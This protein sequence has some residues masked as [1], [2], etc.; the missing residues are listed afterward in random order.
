[1]AG[2]DDFITTAARDMGEPEHT[3]RAATGALLGLIR[4]HA[5]SS[6][7]DQLL[8]AIPGASAIM[9]PPVQRSA[10]SGLLGGLL[11]SAASKLG[12]GSSVGGAISVLE[13]IHSTGFS[14]HNVT[15]LVSMFTSFLRANTSG[16][17]AQRLLRDVPHLG[18]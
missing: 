15:R 12:L 10:G 18:G 1:V 11:G 7:V 3:T 5:H 14:A 9:P 17:L 13:S 8:R 16:D 4:Q 6:D 2:I